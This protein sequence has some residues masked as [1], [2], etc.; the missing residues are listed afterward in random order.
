VGE[1][2]EELVGEGWSRSLGLGH[3]NSYIEWINNKVLLYSTRSYIQYSEINHNGKEYEKT[4]YV[5]ICVYIYM[6]VCVCV[7]MYIYIY[8]K[9]NHQ[10]NGHELGQILGGL[11]RDRE[12]WCAIVHKVVKSWT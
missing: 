12:A 8:I 4:M 3:A 10:C 9:L 6:C 1:N 7:Y 11:V 2:V 5:C